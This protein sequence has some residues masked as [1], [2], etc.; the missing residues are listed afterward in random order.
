MITRRY[1]QKSAWRWNLFACASISALSV[2]AIS[3]I[4]VASFGWPRPQSQSPLKTADQVTSN[5]TVEKDDTRALSCSLPDGQNV[6][7]GETVMGMGSNWC[8]TCICY[9][10]GLA[11]TR[12][13][14]VEKRQPCQSGLEWSECGSAC[15]PTC[16]D[17]LQVCNERCVP[18]CKCPRGSKLLSNSSHI[19]V[20]ECPPR[21]TE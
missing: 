20:R 16:E 3:M 7:I 17:P 10:Y 11:C 8:N 6:S 9:E 21:G 19:C 1:P 2:F 12:M 14:C 18:K 13:A 15:P 5:T 4:V